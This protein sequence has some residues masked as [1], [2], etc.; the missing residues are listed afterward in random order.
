M[1]HKTTKIPISQTVKGSFS[2]VNCILH[3]CQGQPIPQLIGFIPFLVNPANH[4]THPKTI[5]LQLFSTLCTPSSKL[6]SVGTPFLIYGVPLAN[7]NGI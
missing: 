6:S 3:S 7:D 1:I 2:V 5:I 4:Q